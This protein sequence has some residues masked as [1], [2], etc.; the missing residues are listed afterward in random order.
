MKRTI[1]FMT[2]VVLAFT[3]PSIAFAEADGFRGIKWGTDFS[4][5]KDMMIFKHTDS[6]AGG[7]KV[8]SKKNDDLKIGAATLISIEY[9]FWQNKFCSV[10]IDFSNIGNFKAV[11]DAVFEKFG[12]GN[13]NNP[14]MEHYFWDGEIS[15]MMLRYDEIT[16]D[17]YLYLS[18]T[19]IDEQQKEYD[20]EQAKKGAKTGF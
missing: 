17:G 13:K 11:K 4:S 3:L 14:Y 6:S 16:N 5:V 10:Y 8:Y 18:S 20:S 1:I 12:K 2:L 19:K 7:V 9:N 15:R